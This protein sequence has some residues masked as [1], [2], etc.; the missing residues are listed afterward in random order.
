MAETV[1]KGQESLIPE[2][3]PWYSEIDIM[4]FLGH[5]NIVYGTLHYCTFDGQKKS[6]SRK[7]LADFD[8]TAGFHNYML[9]WEPGIMRWF[10]DDHLLHRTTNGIPH[11]PHYLILN[12]A[13]G[14]KWPGNPDNTTAFPQYHDID[15]V[16][17]YAKENYY[18]KGN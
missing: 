6:S 4:E 10:I 2:H 8:L 7:W 1:A 12:T 18:A 17:V 3:R 14:G 5:T 9:E 16:R 15:Y 11:T 13:I